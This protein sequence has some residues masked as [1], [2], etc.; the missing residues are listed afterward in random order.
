M[1][2]RIDPANGHVTKE[3]ARTVASQLFR[4]IRQLSVGDDAAVADLPLAQLRVCGTLQG[5]AKPMSTLGRE[6][7]ISLAR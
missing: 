2:K 6:L 1:T 7:G 4:L 5:G 3:Q